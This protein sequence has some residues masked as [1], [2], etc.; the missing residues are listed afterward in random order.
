[1][2]APTGF[3]RGDRVRLVCTDDPHTRL[4]PGALG[5]VTFVDDMG[6]V[7]V[8]WDDGSR[9]GMVEEAGDRVERLGHVARYDE[10]EEE[11]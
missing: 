11:R 8:D 1:M 10:Q 7:H 4:E 5:I 3:V 2:S 9:L 6:T